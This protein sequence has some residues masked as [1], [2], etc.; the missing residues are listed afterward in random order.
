MLNQSSKGLKIKDA[1]SPPFLHLLP[2]ASS[3]GE[4]P[5]HRAAH[6]SPW[7][8]ANRFPL[9]P[10]LIGRKAPDLKFCRTCPHRIR[11]KL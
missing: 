5:W 8:G 11:G 6:L 9:P 4:D 10:M 7:I 2:I 1:A 3:V